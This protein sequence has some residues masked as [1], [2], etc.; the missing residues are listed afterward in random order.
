MWLWLAETVAGWLGQS[1]IGFVSTRIAAAKQARYEQQLAAYKAANNI[2][3]LDAKQ[4]QAST[5]APKTRAE[6]LAAL[7]SKDGI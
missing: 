1:A 2:V 6:L 7:E 4:A 5:D 3:T